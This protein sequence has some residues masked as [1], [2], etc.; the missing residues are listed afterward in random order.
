MKPI[1]ATIMLA[2]DALLSLPMRRVEALVSRIRAAAAE[3][4]KAAKPS[5]GCGGCGG[6]A[7]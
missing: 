5:G 2:A 6:E 3:A 4:V 7:K 1:F